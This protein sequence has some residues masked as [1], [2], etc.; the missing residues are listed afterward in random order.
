MSRLHYGPSLRNYFSDLSLQNTQ[1]ILYRCKFNRR[2]A[3]L[4]GPFFTESIALFAVSD[5][6]IKG[7]TRL[8]FLAQRDWLLLRDERFVII[9]A[10]IFV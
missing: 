10:Q 4:P 3:A 7:K 8:T 6:I 9:V 5:K 1:N 2:T